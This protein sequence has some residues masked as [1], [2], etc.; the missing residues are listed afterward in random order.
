MTELES[1]FRVI[2]IILIVVVGL[3]LA[4]RF[5]M[6]FFLKWL[7]RKMQ[8]RMHTSFKGFS[9]TQRNASFSKQESHNQ[10]TSQTSENL[11]SKKVVGEYIDFEEVD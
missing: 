9:G 4:F 7:A 8:Q 11:K 1:F 10:K 6:P 3:R 2:L 5:L